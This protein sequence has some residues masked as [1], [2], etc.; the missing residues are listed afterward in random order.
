[1]RD[2]AAE[3]LKRAMGTW[4]ALGL[5]VAVI[6]SFWAL[7]R[8]PGHLML[9]L[10]LSLVAAVQGIVLQIAINRADRA[11]AALAQH[12]AELTERIAAT[13]A[14]DLAA[15]R[16]SLVIETRIAEHLGVDVADLDTA[17][18]PAAGSA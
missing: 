15:D 17:T 7:V 13:G 5:A 10:G 9:N 14:R 3:L 11:A 1:M 2:R 16:A 12:V 4:T 8:D 6:A 18:A